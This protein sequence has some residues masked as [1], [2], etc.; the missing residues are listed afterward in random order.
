VTDSG[1]RKLAVL[2]FVSL[3]LTKVP[4]GYFG[5]VVITP[6]LLLVGAGAALMAVHWRARLETYG[7]TWVLG[8]ILVTTVLNL[9]DAKATSIAYSFIFGTAF[10]VM[11]NARRYLRREDFLFAVKIIIFAYF[12][13][14]LISQFLVALDPTDPVLDAIFHRGS[15][16]RDDVGLRYY[17]FS[18]EPSYAAI[19]V[20]V[21]FVAGCEL[22]WFEDRRSLLLYALL[23]AYQVRAFGSVYGYLIGGAAALWIA[24]RTLGKAELVALCT[25][26]VVVGLFVDLRGEGRVARIADAVVSDGTLELADLQELDNSMFMRIAPVVVFATTAVPTTRDLYVG[27]GAM[28]HTVEYTEVF[29]FALDPDL[30][31]EVGFLPGFLYDFGIIGGALTLFVLARA[32]LRRV[33]SLPTLIV[34]ATLFNA[35]FNTQ[36]FW[37][38]FVTFA[39]VKA[40]LSEE[41]STLASRPVSMASD[42]E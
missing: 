32:S 1:W 26:L 24:Y 2:L 28:A 37:Y 23:T 38:V 14:V 27:R 39:Y 21:A 11:M 16:G 4:V 7:M 20:C 25:G 13:N 17:G 15:D 34:V 42:S 40:F 19:I 18:S 33:I 22:S 3:S 5:H 30:I 35:N 36:L 29:S 12:V 10:V 6:F 9:A 31:F 41:P 8:W